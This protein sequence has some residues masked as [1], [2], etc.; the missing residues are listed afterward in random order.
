MAKVPT[1]GQIIFKCVC[2]NEAPADDDDTLMEQE[3]IDGVE[4]IQ[5]YDIILDNAAHDPARNIVMSNCR[6]CD[7]DHLTMTRVG[8]EVTVYVCECGYRS[9]Y[10][11][12]HR[13]PTQ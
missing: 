6:D 2:G 7:L 3:V 13:S 9:S 12:H 8:D 11:A 10:T 1:K 4:S 5:K